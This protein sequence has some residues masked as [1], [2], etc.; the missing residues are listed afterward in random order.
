MPPAEAA[1]RAEAVPP[2]KQR[3]AEMQRLRFSEAE[4]EEAEA[5]RGVPQE[6]E[7]VP[8]SSQE[9]AAPL[10]SRLLSEDRNKAVR[11]GPVRI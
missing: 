5:E 10:I 3:R 4:Q 8:P 9:E 11:L 1:P 6:A 2:W 7:A